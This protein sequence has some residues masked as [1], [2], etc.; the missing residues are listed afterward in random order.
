[1]N[2]KN[3]LVGDALPLFFY[4]IIALIV[5]FVTLGLLFSIR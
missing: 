5:L 4:Y 3:Y 1:M 2:L